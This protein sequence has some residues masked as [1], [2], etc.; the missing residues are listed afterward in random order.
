MQTKLGTIRL[1]ISKILVK[2]SMPTRQ[3]AITEIISLFKKDRKR[4]IN[5][6]IQSCDRWAI[7]DEYPEFIKV[8]K[9]LI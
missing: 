8:I 7:S 1:K 2:W 4:L 9:K 3:V 6:V 5:Q